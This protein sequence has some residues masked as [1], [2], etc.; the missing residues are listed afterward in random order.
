MRLYRARHHFPPLSSF[1]K[2][3]CP[4]LTTVTATRG[5]ME[6]AQPQGETG[7]FGVSTIRHFPQGEK[8]RELSSLFPAIKHI[9]C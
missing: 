8:F 6:E 5:P 4:V 9:E 3:P 7:G 2:I 1:Q